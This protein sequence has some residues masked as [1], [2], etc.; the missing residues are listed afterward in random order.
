MGA[1]RDG[2][3]QQVARGVG[4]AVL[5]CLGAAMQQLVRLA[6]A[7][8]L[9]AARTIDVRAG[10]RV[11]AIEKQDARPDVNGL[12]VI[13]GEVS[14]Q[15]DEQELLDSRVALVSFERVSG[16]SVGRQRVRH[17]GRRARGSTPRPI[18]G[19]TQDLRNDFGLR[20]TGLGLRMMW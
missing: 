17:R 9:R 3:I 16:G 18:I 11:A 19:Q 12:F 13:A 5:E 10:T 14:I 4:T 6:L 20:T 1:P 2:G 15:T 8:G 7:L